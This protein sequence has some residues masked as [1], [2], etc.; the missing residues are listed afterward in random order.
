MYIILDSINNLFSPS[1]D[2][3]MVLLHTGL[4]WVIHKLSKLNKH[5]IKLFTVSDGGSRVHTN[6]IFIAG[7]LKVPIS[8]KN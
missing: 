7:K 2:V 1:R 3:L 4:T 8:T 6:L 5:Q